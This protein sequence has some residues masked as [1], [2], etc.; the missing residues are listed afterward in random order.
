LPP[1]RELTRPATGNCFPAKLDG[2]F[3]PLGRYHLS[4]DGEIYP[5]GSLPLRQDKKTCGWKPLSGG[6][7]PKF[8]A[9]SHPHKQDT[10]I[11]HW[12]LIPCGSKAIPFGIGT[13]PCSTGKVIYA[14]QMP[15]SPPFAANEGQI[16]F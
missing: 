13:I 11:V 10:M 2:N 7:E 9:G 4:L 1:S 5:L 16:N 8:P 6:W 3:H 14:L 15:N 12:K